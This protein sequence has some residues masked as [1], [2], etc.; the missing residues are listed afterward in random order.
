MFLVII[1]LTKDKYN[2]FSCISFYLCHRMAQK[3]LQ[4]CIL[5]NIHRYRQFIFHHVPLV[6]HIPWN[7]TWPMVWADRYGRSAPRLYSYKKQES[8]CFERSLLLI[9]HLSSDVRYL[10]VDKLAFN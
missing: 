3:V 7:G 9:S 6:P 4:K 2:I 10:G 8:P 1:H 5:R